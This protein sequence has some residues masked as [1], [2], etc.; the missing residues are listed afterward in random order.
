ME[1]LCHRVGIVVR[2]ELG[3]AAGPKLVNRPAFLHLPGGRPDYERSVMRT[4]TRVSLREALR[5]RG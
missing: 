5:P 4:G 3:P 2:A 1:R